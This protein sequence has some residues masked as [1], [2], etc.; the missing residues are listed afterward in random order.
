[1]TAAD[2]VALGGVVSTGLVGAGGLVVAIR[3][4]RHNVD[5]AAHQTDADARV[6]IDR[7]VGPCIEGIGK[8]IAELDLLDPRRLSG[9]AQ[10]EPDPLGA[11]RSTWSVL[12]PE[13][14]SLK[15]RRFLRRRDVRS[16][17]A[18]V[19]RVDELIDSAGVYLSAAADGEELLTATLDLTEA[20]SRTRY[21]VRALVDDL[22]EQVDP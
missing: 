7:E 4:H 18:L 13:L 8:L 14:L 21:A 2:W 10:P 15:S 17:H 6:A 9:W 11:V 1:M 20:W 12:K 19:R 16:I 5:R 22:R 3:A